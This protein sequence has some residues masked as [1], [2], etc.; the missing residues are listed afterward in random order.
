MVLSLAIVGFISGI[1]GAFI[2]LK[3]SSEKKELILPQ[4]KFV[5]PNY[6]RQVDEVI[7]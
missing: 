7:E 2:Y 6:S 4:M 1:L 5:N 3:V